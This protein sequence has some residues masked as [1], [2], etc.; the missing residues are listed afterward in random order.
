M[1][2]D[3]KKLIIPFSMKTSGRIRLVL[4]LAACLPAIMSGQDASTGIASVSSRL[5]A[6]CATHPF[7]ELW[8]HTDRETYVAGEMV[9]V[10]AYLLSYPD[11][12]IS[13]KESYAYVELLDYYNNPVAQATIQLGK[14]SGESG[15]LLPDSLVSGSYLLRAY[16][17]VMKNYLPHG[18]FMK[19]ITVANPFRED[20]LDLYTSLK[21]SHDPPSRIDFYPEGGTLV[22]GLLTTVGVTVLNQYGYPAG[23]SAV[24]TNGEDEV[25]AEVTVDTTGI[26]SFDFVPQPGESYFFTPSATGQ[27]YPIPPASSGGFN[28]RVSAAGG[29]AVS[30]LLRGRTAEGG[31]QERG[32]F[33]L[34]QSG[35]NIMFTRE[36]PS[37]TGEYEIRVPA[38][39][40]AGGM[41]NIAAFDENG[42]CIAE[43]YFFM[44]E[45]GGESLQLSYDEHAG[46]RTKIYLEA[47]D[48]Q[49]RISTD[50]LITG[51][52]SVSAS[53]TADKIMTASEYLLLGS[54]FRHLSDSPNLQ[55]IF[56]WLTPGA[57]N[58]FLL[59]IKSEW[60]NW[61]RIAAGPCAP[62]LFPEEVNGRY[63]VASL[64]GPPV[65][66][67][68]RELT[69]FLVGWGRRQSFQYSKSDTAR[70]FIF[71]LE[72]KHETDE[73]II[74]AGD[75][76]NYHPL[77]LESRFSDRYLTNLFRPD[78]TPMPA[79]MKELDKMAARYQVRK[80]Y[81]ITDT[82]AADT[83]K[84]DKDHGWRFYGIPDQELILDN[85]ISLSSM[86]E[87]FFELV[88]RMTVRSDRQDGKP[89]IWDPVLKRSPA[90][91]IDLVPVE[92]AETILGLDPAHVKQIDIITGDYLFGEIV[93]PGILNVVTRNG[94]FTETRLPARFLRTS[95]TMADP[96]SGFVAPGHSSEGDSRIPD[97][98]N[99]IFWDGK[100]KRDSAGRFSAELWSSDD[101]Q[102]CDIT[103]NLIDKSGKIISARAKLLLTGLE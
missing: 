55:D 6:Y 37:W 79:M 26:G 96:P 59:G 78:T 43:R 93:F 66:S 38:S 27:R 75:T 73:I 76:G 80:I 20:F 42:K 91:F 4:F 7:E 12:R 5:E 69:A 63:L 19:K 64:A 67:A 84:R 82:P 41:N 44:P 1:L 103:V 65:S 74:K 94:N 100:L 31:S 33:I 52:I 58:I 98:R 25:I 49:S 36:L 50:E 14:G 29:Q 97:F 17:G 9:R 101:S 32:G 15:F 61:D 10:K 54:Q 34:I 68:E 87:I 77:K 39:R 16:T 83:T 48:P 13:E 22:N 35:G 57:R 3:R 40:M 89:V 95:Y 18:C 23:C 46:R 30:I 2:P 99:T 45:D 70:R 102:N 88:K 56:P 11:L 60:I 21:F 86:R 24:V 72:R 28:L 81:G 53:V 92:D 62:P 90:L 8:L 47:G 51:S 71:F 85:Y